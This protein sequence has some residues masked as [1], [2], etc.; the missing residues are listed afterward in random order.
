MASSRPWGWLGTT[1]G[2]PPEQSKHLPEAWWFHTTGIWKLSADLPGHRHVY[3]SNGRAIWRPLLLLPYL[4]MRKQSYFDDISAFP[5]QWALTASGSRQVLKGS[6]GLITLNSWGK[7][8]RER[9]K[10]PFQSSIY[11]FEFFQG[12]NISLVQRITSIQTLLIYLLRH[13]NR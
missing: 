5:Q 6:S 4:L 3:S 13:E 7:K 1:Q 9:E 12:E 10:F 8:K 11:P 2:S